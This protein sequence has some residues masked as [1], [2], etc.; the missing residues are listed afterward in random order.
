MD[1]FYH[2]SEIHSQFSSEDLSCL[3]HH[4]RDFPCNF[5]PIWGIPLAP[6]SR[7]FFLRVLYC[8]PCGSFQRVIA[9]TWQRTICRFSLFLWKFLL[10]KLFELQKSLSWESVSQRKYE[11]SVIWL[12]ISFYFLDFIHGTAQLLLNGTVLQVHLARVQKEFREWL[13]LWYH[14]KPVISRVLQ[15]TADISWL[16]PSISAYFTSSVAQ[17]NSSWSGWQMKL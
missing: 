14:L 13:V 17:R 2:C 10:Y 8:T 6:A 3:S 11:A 1:G 15:D 16:I 9:Q 4:W 12:V 5:F 7:V